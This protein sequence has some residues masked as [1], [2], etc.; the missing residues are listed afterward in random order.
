MTDREWFR[1][2]FDVMRA[3]GQEYGRLDC[4]GCDEY[5]GVRVH[6][7]TTTK[8]C[9]ARCPYCGLEETGEAG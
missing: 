5:R 8:R 4:P 3:Q 2:H 1:R 7:A 6:C 9:F